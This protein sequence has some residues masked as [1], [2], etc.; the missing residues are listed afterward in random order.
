MK[1]S[2]F[3]TGLFLLAVL[4]AAAGAQTARPSL[5]ALSEA[6]RAEHGAH[7]RVVENPDSGYAR[8]LWGHNSPA[9]FAPR[10]DADYEAIARGFLV[11]AAPLFGL[12]PATLV[13]DS[14]SLLPLAM[15]GTTDKMSVAFRQEVNGVPVKDGWN[16]VLLG[17]DGRLLAMDFTGLPNLAGLDTTPGTP[18][19]VAAR[20]AEDAFRAETGL[21]V[22]AVQ[23]ISLAIDR[24]GA[25]GVLAWQVDVWFRQDELMPEGY[26]YSIPAQGDLRVLSRASLVHEDVGGNVKS[27]ATPGT[28]PDTSGNPETLHTMKYMRVTGAGLGTTTTDANGNFN[29]TGSSGPVNVTFEYYGTYNDVRNQAGADYTLTV[30]LSGTGNSVTM[31]P[32]LAQ[33]D[34]AQANAFESI[35]EMR[36]WTRAVDPSDA[37]MDYI[38]RANVNIASY[39]NA[40]FDG[41]STNYYRSGGGC[42]NTAYSTVI[43][44]EQGHWQN[45]RYNSGNGWDGFGEGNADV[46][47]MFIGNTPIVGQNFCGTGCNIRTGWNMRQYCGDGNG[48]CY[49]EVH[50]DGEVLMGA[51]WK[52]RNYIQTVHGSGPGGDIANALFLGW[53]NAYNQTTIHSIIETQWLTLDDDNGDIMDGTPNYQS[54]DQ[55][56]LDQGFPGVVVNDPYPNAEF[57]GAPLTGYAPLTVTFTD[58]S[59]G[60]GLSAWSWTFGD[61]GTSALQNPPHVYAAPGTFT[62]ALTVTGT[63]G[64]NT[65]TKVGYV[66]VDQDITASA[67]IRNGSGVNPVVFTTITLPVLGT[68][69][70]SQVNGGSI[71][72]SGLTFLVGYS[73][74]TSGLIFAPGEL[75]IDVSSP[76]LFTSIS[77]GASGISYHNIGIPNDPD[78]L[79]F[80]A[81]TQVLL[82][83]VGGSGRLTNA[84]DLILGH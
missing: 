45:V 64:Q 44:H 54:I 68:T 3:L 38:N 27:Y 49:G 34:T 32:G 22:T 31:N 11:A 43:W 10:S 65:E 61:G 67:T 50:D 25:A 74:P 13:A 81:Y 15:V 80:P 8:M 51:L 1:S 46:F 12:E 21:P 58:Q 71:G 4:G 53:M 19:D 20:F 9:A 52:V 37:H 66:V 36:D 29:F 63:L 18:A 62:V 24:E 83:N 16:C 56:F 79:G 57:V 78:L 76:W 17:M 84:L 72:A 14:T 26:Q 40:Y 2:S 75:L 59:S 41:T 30:S 48:G 77:G 47:C 35:N 82:N 28:L 69:W 6:W 42:V 55:G 5:A 7:W 73:A 70:Q 60:D 39:C 33:Y 23:N